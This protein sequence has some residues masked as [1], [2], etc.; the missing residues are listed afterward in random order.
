MLISSIK[1]NNINFTS[2]RRTVYKS[3]NGEIYSRP[4][5][6]PY[7]NNNK[8]TSLNTKIVSANNTYF[9]RADIPWYYLAGYLEQQYPTGKV[10]IYSL[11]CSDGSEPYSIVIDLIAKLGE[12]KANRFFPIKASDVDSEIIKEAKSG[13]IYASKED[14]ERIDKTAKEIGGIGRF[15][16]VV[17]LEDEIE[18]MQNDEKLTY[19]LYPKEILTKNVIFE[20]KDVKDALAEISESE[21]NFILARNFWKYLSA[22]KCANSTFLLRK[23]LGENGRFMLGEYDFEKGFP[24]FS[25]KLGFIPDGDYFHNPYIKCYEIIRCH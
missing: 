20:C 5:Y 21:N 7:I 25:E 17:P 13:K 6:N 4:W 8:D 19:V 16:D 2:T 11:A 10:N 9:F 3:P 24:Y 12:Q 15:F 22:E 14:I 23:N 1:P 18:S